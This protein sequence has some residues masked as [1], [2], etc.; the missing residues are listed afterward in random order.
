MRVR[1][2]VLRRDA[3][4]GDSS[5]RETSMTLY[6]LTRHSRPSAGLGRWSYAALVVRPLSHGWY[7]RPT[8]PPLTI[9]R[10]CYAERERGGRE[11]ENDKELSVSLSA[12]NRSEFTRG[13][14]SIRLGQV[15]LHEKTRVCTATSTWTIVRLGYRDQALPVFEHC[16][17]HARVSQSERSFNRPASG[18]G[19]ANV[20]I[21]DILEPLTFMTNR[22]TNFRELDFLF[23]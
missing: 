6:I 16:K 2:C 14:R 13:T 1:P 21:K 4:R 19:A 12:Y 20:K 7:P 17:V 9:Y 23:H 18:E 5:D 3:S 10:P 11:R 15:V 8:L 22:F